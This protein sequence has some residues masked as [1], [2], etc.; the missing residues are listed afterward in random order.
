MEQ[1]VG[2]LDEVLDM[3]FAGQSDDLLVV[4]NNSKQLK[5]FQRP[6]SSCQL[7]TGHGGVVLALDASP[8]GC[9]L[10]TGSKDNTVRMWEL[11]S[12][13]GNFRCVASGTG[14]THAVGTVSVSRWVLW[15]IGYP[16]PY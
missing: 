14:H 6:T 8:D 10:V 7:L 1:L 4:A 11:N 2:Y 12:T 9:T 13:S 15:N 5:V 3:R 16:L